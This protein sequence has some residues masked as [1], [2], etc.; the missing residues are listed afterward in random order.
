MTKPKSRYMLINYIQRPKY[1]HRTHEKGY[2]SNPENSQWD[3]VVEFSVGLKKRDRNN[4]VII[5]LDE[6]QVVKNTMNGETD[7]PALFAYY[8]EHY[9]QQIADYLKRSIGA[10]KQ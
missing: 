7:F 3:E 10:V 8:Q 4:G 9:G 5:N 6:L 2:W 1:P